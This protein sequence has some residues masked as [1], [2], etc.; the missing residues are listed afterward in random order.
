MD[1]I[2]NYYKTRFAEGA[3][4]SSSREEYKT[5]SEWTKIGLKNFKRRVLGLCGR[6]SV[7][8]LDELAG[9]LTEM[10]VIDSPK[11]GPEF[12]EGLYGKKAE[13]ANGT[14]EFTEV[15]NKKGSACKINRHPH[16]D[17]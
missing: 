12:I 17:I 11:D 3:N 14:L 16:Y 1:P 4:S 13:Y 7:K 15:Q 8:S 10:K 2:S 9:I 5:P 6:E